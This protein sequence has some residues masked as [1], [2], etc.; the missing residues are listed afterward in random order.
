MN[1]PLPPYFDQSAVAN[2]LRDLA[3]SWLQSLRDTVSAFATIDVPYPNYPLP[4]GFPFCGTVFRERFRW[5]DVREDNPSQINQS[6]YV[7]LEL[8]APLDISSPVAWSL[9]SGEELNLLFLVPD[10]IS[11]FRR[12]CRL[13]LCLFRSSN[14][15]RNTRRL[16]FSR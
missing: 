8:H 4:Q 5:V 9:T 10:P 16:R 1:I 11:N 3:C 15:R 13:G 6:Y 12:E 7:R 14:L 2:T